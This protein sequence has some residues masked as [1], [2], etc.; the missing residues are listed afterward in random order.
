MDFSI[1]VLVCLA[2]YSFDRVQNSLPA[3]LKG[4]APMGSFFYDSHSR[5]D[6]A[7]ISS[8]MGSDRSSSQTLI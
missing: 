1:F 3:V 8:V 2:S 5:E 6:F 4:T 7:L